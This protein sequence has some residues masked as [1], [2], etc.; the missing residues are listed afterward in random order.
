MQELLDPES[1]FVFDDSMQ[2]IAQLSI[3]EA[4]GMCVNAFT[5]KGNPNSDVVV[6]VKNKRFHVDKQVSWDD[7]NPGKTSLL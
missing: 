2:I 3:T 7:A 5:A 4:K 6:R 1:R